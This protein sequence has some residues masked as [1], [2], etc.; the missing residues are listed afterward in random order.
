MNGLDFGSTVLLPLLTIAASLGT[1]LVL[2]LVHRTRRKIAVWGKVAG[3]GKWP[4]SH[5]G[6]LARPERWLAIKQRKPAR[7]QAALGL[8]HARS[9]SWL[10]GLMGDTA[11]FIAPPRKG[12]TVVVGSGLPDPA[13]DVDECFRF[14]VGLSRKVG[15]VQFFS[16]NRTVHHHAW[17]WAKGGR[18]VRAY[19][20]TGR[21]VWTQGSRTPAEQELGLRCFDYAESPDGLSFG[22]G[23]F[24]AANVEKVPMLAARWGLD[25]ADLGEICLGQEQ[26]IAGERS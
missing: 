14:L 9:C 24:L 20:W 11:F 6:S 4:H 26:G 15:Q 3:T 5:A 25:P 1:V 16:A 10:E 13:V 2:L 17:V 8:H 19:A 23:E 22:Q 18:V 12:W 21:T 7:I